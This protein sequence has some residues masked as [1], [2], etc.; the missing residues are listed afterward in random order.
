MNSNFGFCIA[1]LEDPTKRVTPPSPMDGAH[2]SIDT[3]NADL[4]KRIFMSTT[5][6][7]PGMQAQPVLQI[8]TGATARNTGSVSYAIS[9]VDP[10][11]VYQTAG[12]L[13]GAFSAKA[14]ELFLPQGG[15]IPDMYL[16]TPNLQIEPLRDQAATYGVNTTAI[17]TLLNKSAS[18][19]YT[20][21]IK[22]PTNQYQVI[23]EADDQFRGQCV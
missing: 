20:Y 21:L 14:G 12:K 19:N 23:L 15:I 6:V 2:A 22:R 9:G 1:F 17:E 5:G 18:Q 3:V 13:M 10:A 7:I 8:S 16:Q 4:A 11:E